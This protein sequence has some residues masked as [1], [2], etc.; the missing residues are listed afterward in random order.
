M[1]VLSWKTCHDPDIPIL[2]GLLKDSYPLAPASTI[3]K[4]PSYFLPRRSILRKP[5]WLCPILVYCSLCCGPPVRVLI[6]Y[7][8]FL[9]PSQEPQIIYIR[10]GKTEGSHYIL[11]LL[12]NV[13]SALFYIALVW[14]GFSRMCEGRLENLQDHYEMTFTTNP[15][16]HAD[17]RKTYYHKTVLRCTRSCFRMLKTFSITLPKC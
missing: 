7:L 13:Q 1:D 5:Y 11:G 6:K 8:H 12:R 3:G 10:L 15:L 17:H 9:F 16:Y 14:R 4:G 2:F